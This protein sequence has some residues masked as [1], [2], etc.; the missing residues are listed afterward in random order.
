ML[1]L[2]E[3]FFFLNNLN[4]HSYRYNRGAEVSYCLDSFIVFVA[5]NSLHVLLGFF[6]K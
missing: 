1:V 4:Y 5:E 6:F 2:H 3:S